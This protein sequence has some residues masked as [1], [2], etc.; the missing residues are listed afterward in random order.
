MAGKIDNIDADMK[1]LKLELMKERRQQSNK[2]S[3]IRRTQ[4]EDPNWIQTSKRVLATRKVQRKNTISSTYINAS[5]GSRVNRKNKL[6]FWKN[7][8]TSYRFEKQ[9][10]SSHGKLFAT[11][12]LFCRILYWELDFCV[13][14]SFL[15]FF[16]DAKEFVTWEWI[17]CTN[18]NQVLFS[19]RD[20]RRMP[21]WRYGKVDWPRR[22]YNQ[23][24]C[25]K[26]KKRNFHT[27]SK[28]R[29]CW[30]RG[31]SF[32]QVFYHSHMFFF[33][34]RVRVVRTFVHIK[35]YYKMVFCLSQKSSHIK[36]NYSSFY[37]WRS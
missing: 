3:L 1:K 30:F 14:M 12:K 2:R 20:Q 28:M 5:I 27:C 25:E 4:Q 19:L 24:A 15:F 36:S 29:P 18:E 33:V 26:K 31:N 9:E 7:A 10:L 32:K 17:S 6:A 37:R 34:I 16:T 11:W 23:L 21:N 35:R 22:R 8:T 13:P